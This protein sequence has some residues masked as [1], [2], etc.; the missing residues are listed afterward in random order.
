MPTPNNTL[1]NVQTYQKAELAFL[2]NSFCGIRMT[3][4]K[5]ENFQDKTANLGDT[6]TFD[7]A[8]RYIG[9]NGLVITQ[10]PSVQRV[11]SLVCSQAENISSGYTDQQF[12]FNVRDYMDRFGEAA[13]KELGSKIEADILK[14]VVSGVRINDPQN[15]SFGSLQV[16]SGPYRFYGDGV[17]QINSY[18]QLA[19]ALA[20]F[21][22]MGAASNKTRGILP[23]T[24]IPGIITT[25]L[26][27][28]SPVTNE[29]DKMSWMLGSFDDCEWFRSNL[30]P[31]HVSGTIGDTAAPNNIMTVVSTNDPTGAN[32]TQITFSEPTS[33]TD[34]NAIKAGDLF[35]FNDG[36]SGK[37]NMRALTF[38][39]HEVSAQPVQFRAIADAGTIGGSVTVSVQ[40]V[41]GIGLVWAQNQNQNINN[42]ITA[43]MKVTPL[44]SH[45][46]GLIYSGDTFY[47]A[48]P[49]LPDESPFT[50]VNMMDMDSGASIRHYYGSQFGKN[51]RAYVRDSIWGSCLVSD[52]CMRL[53]FPI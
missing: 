5:F 22:D 11:Q 49:K 21:R 3:N 50:T 10:Q 14:N 17:T 30:L 52:N 8:P 12:L 6:V 15:T 53:I 32:V 18:G 7:L 42:T 40:T 38:I 29:K 26:Q 20:N 47:M 37:P 41:N 51:N 25:G 33:G 39:G 46:A 19:Q 48:M 35:Q 9:Y 31:I 44:P 45:R 4:K 36:V 27:Q 16:N 2:L 28:F 34:A 24:V 23:M 43:G 13:M 1:Q